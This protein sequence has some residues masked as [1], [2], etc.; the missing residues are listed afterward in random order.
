MII[1]S[2]SPVST[3][4]LPAAPK[5]AGRAQLAAKAGALVEHA[6]AEAVVTEQNIAAALSPIENA[7]GARAM[8]QLLRKQFLAQPEVAMR[9]QANQLPQNAL[10]LLQ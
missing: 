10:R 8:M 4:P 2:H 1:Q 5:N 6:A 7:E 3:N 9:A